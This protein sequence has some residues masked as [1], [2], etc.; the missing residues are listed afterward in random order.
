MKPSSLRC[1]SW[2]IWRTDRKT[3][4]SQHF[5][6]EK[7]AKFGWTCWPKISRIYRFQKNWKQVDL[8][9]FPHPTQKYTSLCS[10]HTKN[11]WQPDNAEFD[12]VIFANVNCIVCTRL[13]LIFLRKEQTNAKFS[14]ICSADEKL[15][16]SDGLRSPKI[17]VLKDPE[18]DEPTCFCWCY[19]FRHKTTLHFAKW[20]TK[21]FR[22]WTNQ[23][24]KWKFLYC[25]LFHQNLRNQIFEIESIF[26]TLFNNDWMSV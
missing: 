22:N 4:D 24:W 6:G 23:Y 13:W 20:K 15:E 11:V 26:Y 10:A 14:E 3:N 5:I 2:V 9:E 21:V 16:L 18:A 7:S 12:C 19:P 8:I 17:W 1:K 25:S